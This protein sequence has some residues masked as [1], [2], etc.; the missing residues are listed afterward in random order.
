MFEAEF[1]VA[2]M[3]ENTDIFFFFF[4]LRFQKIFDIFLEDFFEVE[5]GKLPQ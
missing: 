2:V 5:E 1:K 3:V 4:L